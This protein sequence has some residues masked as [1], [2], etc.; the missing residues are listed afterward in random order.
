MLRY[1][2]S[3]FILL[4][5]YSLSLLLLPPTT[6]FSV[7]FMARRRQKGALKRVLDDSDAK[8]PKS[9]R[10]LNKGRGQEITGVT[11]PQDGKVKGWEVGEGVRMAAVN[12]NGKFYALQGECPR[13]AFDLWKGDLVV[14]DPGFEE[15]CL[16]CPTCGTTYALA[17]GQA[18][19][20]LKRTGLGALVGNLA[21]TATS[22]GANRNAKAFQITADEETGQV[23]CRE[24]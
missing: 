13:C 4:G 9:A 1:K 7:V 14:N 17:S 8:P 5:F 18:G 3:V 6:A 2:S 16:A 21:Q 24:K 19:P 15:D 11:L 23:F 20:P 22:T 12:V 10:S